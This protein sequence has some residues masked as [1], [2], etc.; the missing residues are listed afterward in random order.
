MEATPD[1]FQD[2][3]DDQG[4]AIESF[5]TT[6]Q[7]DDFESDFASLESDLKTCNAN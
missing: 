1:V 6:E 7:L 5:V 4:G 3:V 2:I